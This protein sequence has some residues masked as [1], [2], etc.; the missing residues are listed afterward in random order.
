VTALD[1]RVLSN[2]PRAVRTRV[3]RR[4]A[5]AAGSPPGTLAAVH[6]DAVD[7]LVTAWRGQSHVDLPGRVRAWRRCEKLLVGPSETR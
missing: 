4:A 7:M 6:V 5:I 1:V 2:L 3:L